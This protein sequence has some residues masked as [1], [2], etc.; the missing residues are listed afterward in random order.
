MRVFALLSVAVSVLALLLP[1]G[2]ASGQG[3]PPGPSAV[4]TQRFEATSLPGPVELVQIVLDFPP[5]AGVATHTHG[6][7]AFVTV[8]ERAITLRG[9][10]GERTYSAGQTVVEQ[11]SE[12]HSA[13]NAASGTT[14]LLASYVLPKGA[15]LTTVQEGAAVPSL[16]P[17]TVVR[18]DY[19]IAE[20]PAQ[21]EVVQVLLDFVPGA[22]TPPH[23]HGGPVLVTVLEGQIT[24]RHAG[25]EQRFGPGAG[26]TEREG[27]LHTAGN[28]GTAKASVVATYLLRRGAELTTVQAAPAAAP[29]A[30]VA[31]PPAPV[32]PA[33]PAATPPAQVPGQLPRTGE[34]PPPG[35]PGVLLGIGFLVGGGLLRRR[36]R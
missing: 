26:W 19:E 29:P 31:A 12:F 3:L 10:G 8:V 6:G 13:A 9:P 15:P 14:R 11:P 28:D 23:S 36:R 35:I 33:R 18:G 5:G 24:E 27:D 20:P 2:A 32:A 1:A 22:W 7:Q 4:I 21:F 17:T 30:P 25:A 16:G 34:L